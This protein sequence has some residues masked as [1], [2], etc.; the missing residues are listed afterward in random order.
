M[1][2]ETGGTV[3][4][5]IAFV[6][7]TLVSE[8]L[9]VAV[10]TPAVTPTCQV[11]GTASSNPRTGGLAADTALICT[12]DVTVNSSYTSPA[13][14]QTP[15]FT[16]TVTKGTTTPVSY[17]QTVSPV[18]VYTEPLVTSVLTVKGNTELGEC[19]ESHVS[20]HTELHL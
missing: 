16:V 8:Q 1:L 15:G 4:Y 5:T 9:G 20:D 19:R 13:V 2:A 17:T 3:R 6:S 10:S 7:A 18:R 12:L 11:G 14:A